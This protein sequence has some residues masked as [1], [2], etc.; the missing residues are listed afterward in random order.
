LTDERQTDFAEIE[1]ASQEQPGRT[2]KLKNA[3]NE[4]IYR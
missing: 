3:R 4:K 1:A 2:K